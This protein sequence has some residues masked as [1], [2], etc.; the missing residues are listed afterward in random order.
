MVHTIYLILLLGLGILNYN[1]PESGLSS[2]SQ[3]KTIAHF[4]TTRYMLNTSNA[5]YQRKIE[6]HVKTYQTEDYDSVSVQVDTLHDANNYPVSLTR[7]VDYY[8]S[9]NDTLTVVKRIVYRNEWLMERVDRW[10]YE[11]NEGE[12]KLVSFAQGA[13]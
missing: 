12:L 11:L 5:R 10:T 6:L 7:T 3:Q 1:Q 9:L 13:E 2:I 4:P 8:R